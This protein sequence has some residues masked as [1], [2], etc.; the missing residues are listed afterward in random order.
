SADGRAMQAAAVCR[1]SFSLPRRTGWLTVRSSAWASLPPPGTRATPAHAPLM[2][3]LDG[4]GS[5][6]LQGGSH[7]RLIGLELT[8]ATTGSIVE[9]GGADNIVV[10]GSWIHGTPTGDVRHGIEA[11]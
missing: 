7:V 5:V 8:S 11:N 9:L 10:D 6:V 4:G 1:G 3:K 2:A